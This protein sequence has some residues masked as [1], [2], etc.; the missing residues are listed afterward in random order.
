M[1]CYVRG[2]NVTT[3]G[4]DP[5]KA[6]RL[7]KLAVLHDL[8]SVGPFPRVLSVGKGAKLTASHQRPVFCRAE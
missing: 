5:P 7:Q 1:L 4:S 6:P 3:S 8:G 2:L